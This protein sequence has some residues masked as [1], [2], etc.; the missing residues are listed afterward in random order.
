MQKTL[1]AF[2]DPANIP[3]KYGGE[4]DFQFGD[5]PVPD[6]AW[7][8]VVKWEG[9]RTG[10]PAGPLFWIHG[11]E[12]KKIKALAVG[13]VHEHERKE[14]VC[15]VTKTLPAEAPANGDAAAAAETKY[16]DPSTAPPANASETV[17]A[18]EEQASAV[19]DGEVVPAS[20]PEP[21]SFTTATDGL[22]GLSL[23]EKLGSIPNGAVPVLT[24][25]SGKPDVAAHA[26]VPGEPADKLD[27]NVKV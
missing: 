25:D 2:I 21:V 4:L 13:S 9:N 10:F 8:H 24:E 1:Q 23:S 15:V 7:E 20:R 12:D 6:P 19:Q 3:K 17:R 26:G 18:Q 16:F 14:A 5:M 22:D 27:E 11:D